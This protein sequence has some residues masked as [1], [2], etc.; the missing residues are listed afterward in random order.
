MISF[1]IVIPARY[2]ATRLPGKPVRLLAGKPMIAHVCARAL[3]TGQPVY[4]ATDDE[5]VREAVADLPVE[6]V[7]TQSH[8]TCG[9]ERVAEVASLLNWN[10]GD[11][12]V[13][14]QGDE[15]LMD[16]GLI[17]QVARALLESR[18]A[19]IATL[20][21]PITQREEMFNPGLVKTVVD[22]W[23]HALYFSRAAIPWHRDSFTDPDAPLPENL[24]FLR[25]IGL[26][27]YMAGFLKTYADWPVS[28]LETVES[29]EQL[30]ILWQGELIAVRVVDKA[31]PAGVDTEAD[32]QRVEA[33]MGTAPQH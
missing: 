33:L 17:E 16:P 8:H 32:L 5:R 11:V 9:T 21:T 26:Y 12:V 18:D 13:N 15:P 31:P 7:M 4:V 25:H 6:V 20:A 1:K 28:T 3:E 14:L 19:H 24:P 30:R 2:G 29:L 23:G 10:R 27:A 22:H